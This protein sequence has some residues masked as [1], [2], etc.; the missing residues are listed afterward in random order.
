MPYTVVVGLQW[1]DEGKGKIVDAMAGAYAWVVRFQGGAN[2][3]HTVQVGDE[4][5]V[6]HLIPSGLLH[7]EVQ[8]GIGPGVVVDPEVLLEELGMLRDRGIE[9]E[10][11]FWIDPRSALVLPHHKLQDAFEEEKRGGIGTTKRGIGPAYRDRA[12]RVGLRVGDL[13]LPEAERKQRLERAL[14]WCE[15][16]LACRYGKPPLPRDEVRRSLEAFAESIRPHVRDVVYAIHQVD[17]RGGHILL[18]G[19][20]GSGLDLTFGSYPYV[21]SSHTIAGGASVGA[22]VPPHRITRVVGILKAYA[23]RVGRGPFPTEATGED[24]QWLRDRGQ[25]YGA[26]TGRP[27]RCGWLDLPFLRY[28]IA[29]NGVTDLVL[30]K[31][32]VLA[33]RPEIP[34]G[35]AYRVEG[36]TW[37][38]PPLGEVDLYAVEVAY[39]SWPGF[40]ETEARELE[41]SA[42]A[43]VEALETQLGVPVAAVSTGPRRRDLKIRRDSLRITG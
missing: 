22:G 31:L 9:V 10:G 36:R 5:F 16:V 40:T 14:D 38:H 4:T 1:G 21:T 6:F 17:A 35:V 30:T 25:E 28:T 26:T 29:L 37:T 12:Q 15:E 42:R 34:V 13:F 32:D 27:R 2:A 18:E 43:Y 24:Q 19:A 33:G 11:R 23:T 20:Q 39:D 3:G 7:P 8:V 41:G